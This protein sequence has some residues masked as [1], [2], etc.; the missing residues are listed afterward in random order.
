MKV[1]IPYLYI[2]CFVFC[3]CSTDQNIDTEI[4]PCSIEEQGMYYNLLEYNGAPTNGSE[5]FY[6]DDSQMVVEYV[7][8]HPQGDYYHMYSTQS[9]FV[10]FYSFAVTTGSTSSLDQNWNTTAGSYLSINGSP[11]PNNNS[12]V[13]TTDIGGSNVG[14]TV[15]IRL[16]GVFLGEGS[17]TIESLSCV[18]ID[19]VVSIANYA[20]ITDGTDL[21]VL[22]ISNP[23]QPTVIQSIT[24]N[25]AYYV[26]VVSSV[27]YIGYFDAVAPFV[28]FANVADPATTSI[29][30]SIAKGTDYGRVSDVIQVDNYTYI[31]DE[32]RGLHILNMANS[33]YNRITI[34]DA[35]SVAL[36][37]TDVFMIDQVNGIHK[38]DA[39]LTN[40]PVNLNITNTQDIDIASYSYN[41]GSFH[42]WV[43]TSNNTV[44]AASIIDGKL[45]KFNAA[46]LSVESEVDINGY[47]TAMAVSGSYAFVSMKASPD[48]PLQSS[49]DGIKMVDTNTMTVVDSKPL[50]NAS[51]VEVNGTY[52]YVTDTNGLHIYNSVT[53]SLVLENTFP[54][55]FGNYIAL[56]N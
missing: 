52:V 9:P 14:D 29:F 36:M 37:G 31:T 56:H 30:G 44:L 42:S 28:S 49:Y 46:T 21:K 55:G 11:F 24:A 26:N 54:A 1:Y 3:S 25:T 12:V 38:Q 4:N 39:T 13:L 45:K 43:R 34:S 15:K 17:Y 7:T 41:P 33:N 20:Y 32:Y 27:A 19:K 18:T 35:M 16:E 10:D 22:D 47:A 6:F 48:A 23:T 50:N 5:N 51:G 8:G 53:G 40:A 2:L